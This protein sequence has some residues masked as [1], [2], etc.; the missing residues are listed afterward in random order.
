M[1]SA[2]GAIFV[3]FDST[4]F[5]AVV[6]PFRSEITCMAGGAEGCVLGR[7]IHKRNGH[8]IAVAAVTPRISPV[9]ARVIPL[10]VMFVFCRRPAVCC[11][12]QVA[13]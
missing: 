5:A 8:D 9:V 3:L 13:L 7:G 11:M 4:I 1:T 2:L 10:L 12:T 6:I